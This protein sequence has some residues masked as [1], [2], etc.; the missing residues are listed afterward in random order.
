MD[1]N[2]LRKQIDDID[3]QIVSL[4]EERMALALK[5]GE[6]KAAAGLPIHDPAREAEKIAAVQ[7]MAGSEFT[8]E[9][10]TKLYKQIFATSRK[11]QKVRAKV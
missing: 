6:L 1:L 2:E 7:G 9:E 5:I 10:L 8:R 3:R 4:Y 11:Y